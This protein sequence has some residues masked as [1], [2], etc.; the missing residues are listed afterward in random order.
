[1][2][3]TRGGRP[4]WVIRVLRGIG[5]VMRRNSAGLRWLT[6]ACAVVASLAM[7]MSATALATPGSLE[8]GKCTNVGSGG[9]YANG[10]CTKAAKPGKE[11][12]EWAP[13]STPVKFTSSKTKETGPAV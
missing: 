12:W 5:G 1:M 11:G 13:L 9:K 2:P 6:A 3:P 7:S 8:W 10:G 4:I